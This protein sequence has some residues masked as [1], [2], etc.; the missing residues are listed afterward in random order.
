MIE[1]KKVKDLRD[2]DI[3]FICE[4]VDC[5]EDYVEVGDRFEE[6][7][8]SNENG[9][10]IA[11]LLLE[12]E[13]AGNQERDWMIRELLTVE[14][15]AVSS[16]AAS[17]MPGKKCGCSSPSSITS[18]ITVGLINNLSLLHECKIHHFFTFAI[19]LRTNTFFPNSYSV[20]SSSRFSFSSN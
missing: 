14:K 10:M 13:E 16:R 12:V 7:D 19:L 1:G 4:D 20:S 15:R 17:T 5:H 11:A 2:V 9:G 6:G 18:L 8:V 3:V